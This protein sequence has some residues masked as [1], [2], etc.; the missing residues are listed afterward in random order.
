[1]FPIDGIG[2]ADEAVI[3]RLPD[4]VG[5]GFFFFSICLRDLLRYS[6]SFGEWNDRCYNFFFFLG[7]FSATLSLLFDHGCQKSHYSASIHKK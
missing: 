5:V 7:F 6:G 4:G 2:G 1:M 3:S